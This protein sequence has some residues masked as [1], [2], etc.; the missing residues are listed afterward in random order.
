MNGIEIPC[1][2][3]KVRTVLETMIHNRMRY[4]EE[5][6]DII[7]MRQLSCLK[8][9]FLLALPASGWA[10]LVCEGQHGPVADAWQ[11]SKDQSLALENFKAFLKW[12][13]REDMD[14][15]VSMTG[16]SLLYYAVLADE[17]DVVQHLLVVQGPERLN[18][19]LKYP[20]SW[21]GEFHITPLDAAM[22]YG[23]FAVVRLLL[24][25]K[26]NPGLRNPDGRNSDALHNACITGRSDNVRGWLDFFGGTWNMEPAAFGMNLTY[27]LA[28]ATYIT[29][30][31]HGAVVVRDLINAK[32]NLHAITDEGQ[33]C[34][35]AGVF[36][37]GFSPSLVRQ[38]AAC[39]VDVNS[40]II[41]G[42]FL[43]RMLY[44]VSDVAVKFGSKNVIFEHFSRYGQGAVPL[45]A[46]AVN[47]KVEELRELLAMR[48]DPSIGNRH[49]FT[50]LQK[51]EHKFKVVPS[52]IQKLLTAAEIPR[53]KFEL[54]I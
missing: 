11:L 8:H 28:V 33:N 4:A 6:G 54:T 26:A 39:S 17:K 1:D 18:L 52:V 24:E 29:N 53:A 30:D 34:L 47:G 14:A 31:S 16:R 20:A 7:F 49:G 9:R 50:A 2:K 19:R 23:S 21:A 46:A 12:H 35:Q 44:R 51:A 43:F 3:A 15:L 40:P 36:N 41:A 25:A 27:L 42:T 5:L 37:K 48:A 38:F 10:H 13:P 32:A 45:T 22:I